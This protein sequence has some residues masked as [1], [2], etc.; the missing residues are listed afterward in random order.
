MV[1]DAATG[2]VY[3]DTEADVSDHYFPIGMIVA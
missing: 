2:T 3:L 1:L